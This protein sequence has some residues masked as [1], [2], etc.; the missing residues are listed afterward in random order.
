MTAG[1]QIQR[2]TRARA[3]DGSFQELIRKLTKYSTRLNV[4]R[5][6]S[7]FQQ[8]KSEYTETFFKSQ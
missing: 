1:P 7:H 4:S 2:R 5:E 8:K 6:S 3:E